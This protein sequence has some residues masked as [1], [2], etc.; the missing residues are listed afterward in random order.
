MA[1]VNI[2][3]NV[4]FTTNH[5]QIRFITQTNGD[6]MRIKNMV[7]TQEQA[8]S[9]AWLVNHAENLEIKIKVSE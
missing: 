7:L 9:L 3:D 2:P 8:T 1:T 4:K 5:D 6:E